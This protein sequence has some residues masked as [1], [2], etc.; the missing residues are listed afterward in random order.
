MSTISLSMLAFINFFMV[1]VIGLG[2]YN[3]RHSVPGGFS[4]ENLKKYSIICVLNLP[5][6]RVF[7]AIIERYTSIIVTAETTKYTILA[8][9]SVV[10][11]VFAM[12]WCERNVCVTVEMKDRKQ[13]ERKNEKN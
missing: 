12:E 7:I 11:L 1:P 13:K 9:I 2:I 3:S 4:F 5:L 6:T 10:I 8:V